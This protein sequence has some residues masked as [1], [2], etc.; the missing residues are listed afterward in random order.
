MF[1]IDF[2]KKETLIS[3]KKNLKKTNQKNRKTSEK[4]KCTKKCSTPSEN[5][6]P[7]PSRYLRKNFFGPP[8]SRN[9]N[10]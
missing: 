5:I 9:E 2:S 10:H 4:I 3:Q 6:L 7:P 8:S 1:S